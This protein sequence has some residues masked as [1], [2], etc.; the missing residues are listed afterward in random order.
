M[1]KVVIVGENDYDMNY[2]YELSDGRIAVG[3]QYQGL[4]IFNPS[5]GALNCT[6]R[7]KYIYSLLQIGD[8]LLCESRNS[9]VKYNLKHNEFGDDLLTTTISDTCCFIRYASNVIITAGNKIYVYNS[10]L[11]LLYSFT[12]QVPKE[13]DISVTYYELLP[14]NNNKILAARAEGN[15][16]LIDLDKQSVTLFRKTTQEYKTPVCFVKLENGKIAVK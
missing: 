4:V 11:T 2:G 15:I 1:E 10:S 7:K 8:I 12:S 13:D 14:L 9:V 16:D 6:Y 5:T 3:T